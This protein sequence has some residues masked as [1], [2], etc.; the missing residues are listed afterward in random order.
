MHFHLMSLCVG[1]RIGDTFNMK[2]SPC[3]MFHLHLNLCTT[4]PKHFPAV[5]D[6]DALR[7]DLGL[8]ALFKQNSAVAFTHVFLFKDIQTAWF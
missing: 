8:Q 1:C 6:N 5:C 3:V 7:L 4:T 2:L